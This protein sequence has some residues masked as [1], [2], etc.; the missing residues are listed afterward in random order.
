MRR[1]NGYIGRMAQQIVASD[2]T[3]AYIEDI[4]RPEDPL[5]T[6]LRRLTSELPGGTAMQVPPN[7][8]RFLALLVR[9]TG[10]ARVLEI[11]T[12]TGY[13]ALCMAAAL[14]SGGKV[15]TCDVNR[16]FTDIAA[17]FWDR[18]G[19]ADRID[20]R[21]GDA[22]RT[23]ADLDPGGFDLVFIDA[24]KKSYRAY[25]ERAVELVRPG[26]LIV[27]DNTLFFGRVLDPDADDADTLAIRDVNERIR[28]DDRV[29]HCVLP[30][31]DGVTLAVRRPAAGW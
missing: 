8:A 22:A 13:S 15:V 21:I 11:G 17:K 23:I 3:L 19:V 10:A 14:P 25:Y 1:N 30:F 24:D 12:Y 6:E 20:L 26:G 27:V 16:K 2:A 31:A 4:S 7:E 28:T 5:L 9:L 18:A 29:D